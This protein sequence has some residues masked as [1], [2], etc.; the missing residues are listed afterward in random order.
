MY[1]AP[2]RFELPAGEPTAV[3]LVNRSTESHSF[4]VDGLDVHVRVPPRS[5]VTT[6][7]EPPTAG[8]LPFYCGIPGHAAAG[9]RGTLVVR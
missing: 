3:V 6:L 1:F 2:D 5:T 4:D 8:V 7:L 9:M